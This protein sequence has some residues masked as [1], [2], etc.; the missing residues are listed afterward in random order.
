MASTSTAT[1]RFGIAGIIGSII[2]ETSKLSVIV[3]IEI[4]PIYE[5][6]FQVLFGVVYWAKV[7][8]YKEDENRLIRKI[9]GD[10]II[11]YLISLGEFC[12][13]TYLEVRLTSLCL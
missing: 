4:A 9:Y 5:S 12:S 10:A 7:K 11:Y 6:G 2:F 13:S 3:D 1:N 8:K